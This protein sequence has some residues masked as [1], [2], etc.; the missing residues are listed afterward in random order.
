MNYCII[1]P[2]LVALAYYF[3]PDKFSSPKRLTLISWITLALVMLIPCKGTFAPVVSSIE[4]IARLVEHEP[5][6]LAMLRIFFHNM[7]VLALCALLGKVYLGFTVALTGIVAREI[8]KGY[9]VNV[10][11]GAHTLLELYSYSLATVRRKRELI[12]AVA[13]LAVAA[14]FEVIAIR[15]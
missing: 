1:L 13:Y 2:F 8:A 4:S 7:I 9:P 6:F 14:A 11:L 12:E 3:I 5:I 10:L 15:F